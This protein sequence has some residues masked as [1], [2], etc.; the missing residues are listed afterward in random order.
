MNT[1]YLTHDP[2]PTYGV[3]LV[4]RMLEKLCE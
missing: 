1:L 3:N 4:R 2:L